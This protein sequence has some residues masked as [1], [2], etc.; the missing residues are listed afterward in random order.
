MPPHPPGTNEWMNGRRTFRETCRYIHYSLHVRGSC[1]VVQTTS[2]HSSAASGPASLWFRPQAGSGQARMDQANPSSSKLHQAH[3]RPWLAQNNLPSP[4]S[5]SIES[6]MGLFH[7]TPRPLIP[8]YTVPKGK[9]PS[10][11]EQQLS[12]TG[13]NPSAKEQRVCLMPRALFSCFKRPL[14]A[15]H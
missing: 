1:V 7:Q 13:V 14:A 3:P 6:N 8:P 11:A 12:D 9:T 15:R 10:T 2:W 5:L 4:D